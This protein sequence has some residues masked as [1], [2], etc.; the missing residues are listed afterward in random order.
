MRQQQLKLKITSEIIY[1]FMVTDG[2]QRVW[3]GVATVDEAIRQIASQVGV[4]CLRLERLIRQRQL[5]VN[6]KCDKPGSIHF[7]ILFSK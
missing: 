4:S 7:V 3:F 6:R 2:F 5:Q 1:L